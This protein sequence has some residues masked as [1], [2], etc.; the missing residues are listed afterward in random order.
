MNS[1]E[2]VDRIKK[3]INY[4]QLIKETQIHEPYFK[5]TNAYKYIEDCL[6]TGWVSSSGEWVSKFES[7]IQEFT[8]IKYAV[9]VSNG[10]V[11]LRMAL[12]LVGVKPEDEVL[13]PPLT[14]VATANS[15][16]HLGG[17]PHFVDIDS[18]SLGMCPLALERRLNEVALC[19]G[20]LVYNRFSG[21]R[22]SAILP[23]HVFGFPAK[24]NEIKEVCSK[25]NLPLVEDA[26]EALGSKLKVSNQFLHCGGFG[27]LG[28]LSFN[29]NKIITSGGGGAILTNNKKLADLAKHLS[30]TAKISHPW[31]FFHDQIGWND[32]LPNINAALGASQIENIESKLQK[33]RILHSK[34]KDQF[35]DLYEIEIMEE[36]K[37]TNSNYWLITMRI[38]S[39]KPEGLKEKILQESHASNIY[40]RPSWKLLNELPIFKKSPC[41]DLSQ[42]NNQSKRL[43][44]LPSSPQ[45]IKD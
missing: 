6:D 13:L 37:N 28:V 33:K 15:V 31:D 14:F 32:R 34:F 19:K 42:A 3:V 10:T 43:I 45:L 25:W 29:G 4:P 16:S 39:E 23:V 36:P 9:V 8:G 1:K 17:I 11:A 26:A 24:I 44:N 2:I 12:H 5:D 21:R 20:D 22:I 41:G 7:L 35:E 38:N 18:E 27:D 30:S 40:L